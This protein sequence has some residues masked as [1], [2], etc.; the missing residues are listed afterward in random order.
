M[1]FALRCLLY[2]HLKISLKNW[3]LLRCW[4]LHMFF[5]LASDSLKIRNYIQLK[6]AF[7]YYCFLLI[8]SDLFI[9]TPIIYMLGLYLSPIFSLP[10]LFWCLALRLCIWERLSS[11]S[12]ISLILILQR[13]SR[14]P[15]TA[16]WKL[17]KLT[18]TFMIVP[19]RI[20]L[21]HCLTVMN[22]GPS[23]MTMT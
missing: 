17:S 20:Y 14:V 22:D 9:K 8:C 16:S 12:T 18:L 21:N 13:R 15:T 3:H 1:L 7:S 11:P 2:L 4:S 6:K 23:K 19:F 5:F 10:Y